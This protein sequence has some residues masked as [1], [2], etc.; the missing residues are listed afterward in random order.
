MATM[1]HEPYIRS[2]HGVEQITEP[3]LDRRLLINNVRLLD[4]SAGQ[5]A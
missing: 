5:G 1:L 2:F 3:E 4:A